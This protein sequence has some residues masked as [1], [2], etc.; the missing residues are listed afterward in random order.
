MHFILNT[1]AGG[2]QT[3]HMCVAIP[4][5]LGNK[6]INLLKSVG[7]FEGEN[8][9]FEKEKRTC[10]YKVSSYFD[11]IQTSS[12]MKNCWI[13][14]TIQ[15]CINFFFV[16]FFENINLFNSIRIFNGQINYFCW[17]LLTKVREKRL[18]IHYSAAS[19]IY[20]NSAWRMKC[21]EP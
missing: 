4:S 8:L 11:Q 12:V 19:L 21:R 5:L 14:W 9:M 15:W 20:P 17:T 10:P 1:P 6:A 7:N 3:F 2:Q 16:P 18:S 13:S